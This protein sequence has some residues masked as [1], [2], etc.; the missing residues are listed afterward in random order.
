VAFSQNR[1]SQSVLSTVPLT[2][3][4]APR[5]VWRG[6][7]R[8]DQAFQPSWAPAGDRIAFSAWRAGGLRDILV[9]DVATGAVQEVTR[10]RALDGSPSWSH[11]GR[12]LYFDSD[13]TGISNIYAYEVATGQ[14]WQVTDVIGGAF[15][16][17]VS[18]DGTRLA[19]HGFV[20]NGYDVFELALEPARWTL[21]RPYLDDRPPAVE[22]PDDEAAVSAP[23]PYRALESLAPP[24]WGIDLSLGTIAQG[25]TVRTQG[26]DA[27]G[28]HAYVLATGLDFTRGDL[29]LAASY[30][31]DGLRPSLRISGGRTVRDTEAFEVDDVG[32]DYRE[33]TLSASISVGP[34]TQP[35]PGASWSIGLDYGIDYTRALGLTPPVIDPGGPVPEAPPPDEL[36]AGVGLRVSWGNSRSTTFSVGGTDGYELAASVRFDDPAIG[37]DTRAIS[38]GYSARAYVRMPWGR[39]TT[40]SLRL[41]GSIRDS[42]ARYTGVYGLGG[43]PQQDVLGAIINSQRVGTSGYLRGYPARSST[44]NQYHLFNGE[45]RQPLVEIERGLATLPVY[46]KRLHAAALVDAGTAFD[47]SFDASR[48]RASVGAALRLDAM[49][50]YYVDG[51]FELGYSRGLTSGGVNETWML[52]TSTL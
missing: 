42:D 30:A 5:E 37:A 20:G 32:V 45:L 25:V 47:T 27:A 29:E 51:T 35:T 12:Y 33:E 6:E 16:C 38:A 14:T 36:Q 17:T 50:G 21:A 34:P 4:A 31:Y 18:P 24:G 49:F 48:A 13:R 39:A 22:I 1:S 23:R 46:V 10:D 19:Y 15:E 2:G 3:G 43:T 7:G 26:R 11:D 9:V 41:A 28:R 52:L 8:F 40:A 44:G